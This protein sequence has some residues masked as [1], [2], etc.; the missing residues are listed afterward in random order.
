MAAW[1]EA[2]IYTRARR[3]QL[4]AGRIGDIPIPAAA[5]WQFA[6]AAITLAAMAATSGLW[7]TPAVWTHWPMTIRA[8]ILPAP[9]AAFWLSGRIQ[10]DGTHPFA[11]AAGLAGQAAGRA[12]WGAGRLQRRSRRTVVRIPVIHTEE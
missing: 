9:L 8:V 6:A 1:G 3:H 10:P 12:G 4:L 7:G 11:A 2:R 5:W